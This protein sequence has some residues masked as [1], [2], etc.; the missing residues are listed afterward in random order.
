MKPNQHTTGKKLLLLTILLNVLSV[1][2]SKTN[3][4]FNTAAFSDSSFKDWYYTPSGVF[5]RGYLS[6]TNNRAYVKITSWKNNQVNVYKY[7]AAGI[8]VNTTAINFFHGLISLITETNQWGGTYDS[9]YF[10]ADGKNEFLIQEKLNGENPIAPCTFLKYVF[11]QNLLK[12]IFCLSDSTKPGYNREGVSHYVFDRYE[13]AE[14]FGLVKTVAFFGDIDNPVISRK[15]GCHKIVSTY[16]N[17]GNLTG[18]AAYGLKD[19]PISDVLGNFKTKMKYDKNGNQTEMDYYDIEGNMIN[20]MLGFS[21]AIYDYTNGF[22]TRETCYDA[23]YK[24]VHPTKILEK[25]S[26]IEHKYDDNGNEIQKTYFD[27]AYKPI[28]NNKGIHKIISNYNKTGMLTDVSYFNAKDN[29]ANDEFGIHKYHYEKNN[30]GQIISKTFFDITQ[31][32]TK[33]LSE[34][35]SEIKY[36][37]DNWGRLNHTSYWI[38]DSLKTVNIFGYHEIVNTYNEQGF[39]ASIEFFD[40]NGK[41]VVNYAGYCKEL[42]KYNDAEELSE[43][44]F[45][46]ASGPATL[47]DSSHFI[48]NFHSIRYN[49]D[50]NNRISYLEYLD[51]QGNPVNACIK[52]ESGEKIKC[53]KVEFIYKENKQLASEIFSGNEEYPITVD[54]SEKNCLMVSGLA[55]LL[56]DKSLLNDPELHQQ[57]IVGAKIEDSLFFGKQ[58]AFLGKDTLLFFLNSTASRLTGQSCAVFYRIAPVTKYYQINGMVSDYYIDNGKLAATLTYEEGFLNGLATFY[59]RNGTVKEKGEYKKN[60][61]TGVWE[62]F[63]ESGLK[64]KTIKYTPEGPLLIDCFA[65]NGKVLA[66][67]GN[68]IFEG[69]LQ[70]GSSDLP[71]TCSVTGTVKNGLQDG[72]WKLYNGASTE[73]EDIEKFSEGKFIKGSWLTPSGKI[74]YNRTNKYYTTIDGVHFGEM[75]DQ[76]GQDHLCPF[77]GKK[78]SADR[79]FFNDSKNFYALNEGLRDILKSNRYKDYSGWIFIDINYDSTGS[80]TKKYIRLFSQNDNFRIDILNMLDK[81]NHHP[82]VKADGQQVG[83]EKFYIILLDTND[84]AIPEEVLRKQHAIVL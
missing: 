80:I 64:A 28:N 17:E 13:D 20:Q 58:M 70:T 14:R 61:R 24:I 36:S 6:K 69:K 5:G 77:A 30:I 32:P 74:P 12:E 16:D 1:G 62:F 43:R 19:E 49:Y 48:W 83:F 21:R 56:K 59:Y 67:D 47:K 8:L 66:K 71:L 45:F 72:E 65:E 10:T 31:Q 81:L 23:D 44:K 84:V 60:V 73:P 26:I 46:D 27:E 29:P 78:V 42:L 25:I 68:G 38:N 34:G 18:K 37:Y 50:F 52:L 40:K 82:V 63:Y 76:Y 22:L 2:Y 39:V 54:C 55:I 41:P 3:H 51:V 15:S 35:A 57:K 4:F 79:E 9:I 33:Q 7:N 11:V 53:K 75:V